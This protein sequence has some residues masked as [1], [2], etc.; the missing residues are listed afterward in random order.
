[1]YAHLAKICGL[2]I[3]DTR[4]FDL[5]KKFGAFGVQRF[6]RENGLRIP[7]HTLAGLLHA[8]FRIPSSVDYTTF[9]RATQSLCRDEREV[10]KGFERA[11]FN[12]IFNNRDDH[13][14]NISFQLDKNHHWKLAPCYDLTWSEGPGGEHQMDV[15]GE[16]KL[17][18]KKHL[19]QLAQSSGLNVDWAKDCIEKMSIYANSFKELAKAAP[20]RA[21]TVK[22]IHSSIEKNRQRMV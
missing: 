20:I 6:D 7:I 2:E 18:G 8:D 9:L 17:P 13:P 15:C 14:K 16:G 10:K 22:M 1:M 3:P 19:I 5:N 21:A 11:V 12:I 4:Y